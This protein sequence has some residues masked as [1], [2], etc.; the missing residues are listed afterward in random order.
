M[1]SNPMRQL[2]RPTVEAIEVLVFTKAFVVKR[3]TATG[4]KGRVGQVTWSKFNGVENAWLE[5]KTRA[6]FDCAE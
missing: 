5:A 4:D 6:G 3:T 1:P 2:L